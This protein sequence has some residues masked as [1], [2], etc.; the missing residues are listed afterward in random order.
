MIPTNHAGSEKVLEF[1]AELSKE[2]YV[3]IKTQYKSRGKR[4]D[5]KNWVESLSQPNILEWLITLENSA[6]IA[7]LAY[8]NI[9]NSTK[10]NQVE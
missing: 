8:L 3:N 5:T 10:I 4:M 2:C 7:V 9:W 6:Y 1:A